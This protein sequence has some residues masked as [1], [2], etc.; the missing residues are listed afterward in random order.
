MKARITNIISIAL[1]L[2]LLFS[3][4]AVCESELLYE[5]YGYEEEFEYEDEYIA[6]ALK[7]TVACIRLEYSAS[8][9]Y[10]PVTFN[11][12][13]IRAYIESL[14]YELDG[15]YTQE[16]IS[17]Y[18]FS[19]MK[20]DIIGYLEWGSEKSIDVFLAAQ[21]SGVVISE[22]GYLAT[23]AHVV[24]LT[25]ED[26]ELECI[27]YLQSNIIEDIDEI[28]S[29]L[30]E[31]DIELTTE[32]INGIYETVVSETKDSYTIGRV[33]EELYVC[34]PS[35]DG[36][37]DIEKDRAYKAKVIEKGVSLSLGN[38][39]ITEDAAILKINEESLVALPLSESYPQA[40]SKIVT[41]GFPVAA[42]TV[43][44]AAGSDESVLSV[45]I[46]TGNISRQISV[47]GHDYKAMEI[48]T[49]ISGGNSGGPS[50]DK[51]LNI[52]GLNT[53]VNSDDYRFAYMIPAEYVIDLSEDIDLVRDDVTK[54]FLTGLQMLQKGY[55]AAAY[56]CF[57]YVSDIRED[58]PYIEN[59]MELAQDS[60]W[61]YP[62]GIV[63]N[64]TRYVIDYEL[65][66]IIGGGIMGVVLVAVIIILICKSKK[67]KKQKNLNQNIYTE[68]R[69][70]ENITNGR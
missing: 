24:T 16:E 53:Y 19:D 51:Y 68:P 20:Q 37:T 50:V 2:V 4:S 23:N 48:T 35:S 8:V 40:N 58:T 7:S 31:L 18:V 15:E 12:D 9:R 69:T 41:A 14:Y 25:D 61:E 65:V 3:Q 11:I 10:T 26:K 28:V 29:Q 60:P 13:S 21:G 38:E 43:F 56:E 32:Q 44:Q 70:R 64:E 54:T 49:T 59:L 52:E 63:D 36:D 33:K 39:G 57:E 1:I 47:K 55:G 27:N 62:E 45:S 30:S 5:K 17:E 66:M 46:G 6:H 42:E 67:K 34:F 22:E